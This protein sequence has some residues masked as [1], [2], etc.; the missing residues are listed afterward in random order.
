MKLKTCTKCNTT[1]FITE[2]S[3]RKGSADGYRQQCKSCV[4]AGKAAWKKANQE[5]CR[6]YNKQ[7]RKEN[8]KKSAAIAE[9]TYYKQK[10][11]ITVKQKEEMIAQQNNCCAICQQPFSASKHTCVDHNHQTGDVRGILCTSCNH[12]LGKFKDSITY[13]QNAI[14]YIKKFGGQL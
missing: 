11:G 10:Y 14:A 1:K 4:N 2:F 3:A 5:V 12:G 8:P 6:N 13:M 7:W 9:R